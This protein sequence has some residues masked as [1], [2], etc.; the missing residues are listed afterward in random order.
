MNIPEGLVYTKDHE[1]VRR[2]GATV[3]IGI[4]DFA[5]SELG[6]VVY[7][8]VPEVGARIEAGSPFGTVESVK[9]V[10]EIFA[11]VSGE[12]TE[13]NAALRDAPE[14]VNTDPYGNGWILKVRASSP[15]EFE[16]LLSPAAYARHVADGA[17]H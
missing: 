10:S 1:W 14:T 16:A 12:V 3:T 5:Q 9:A 2:D 13:V 7:V 8:E 17:K 6:D 11:P 4:S 15:Q